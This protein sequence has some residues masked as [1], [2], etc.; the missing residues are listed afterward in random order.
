[1]LH[2]NFTH[3]E[4]RLTFTHHSPDSP[5]FFTFFN[6]N[7][8]STPESMAPDIGNSL[9]AGVPSFVA[10]EE[11]DRYV[12]YWWQPKSSIF[13]SQDGSECGLYRIVY[14]EVIIYTC[15]SIAN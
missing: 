14:E 10:Q 2:T 13:V 6:G 12:G 15:I 8:E 1:M 7:G 9:S 3:P 11:F 5:Q 4:T